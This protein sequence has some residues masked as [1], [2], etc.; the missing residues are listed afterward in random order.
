MAHPD[1]AYLDLLGQVLFEGVPSADRTGNGTIRLFGMSARFTPPKGRFPLL[2][3]KS[4]H[5]KSVA[6]EL[7]WFLSGSTNIKPLV[8]KGVRIWNKDAYRF[9]N[10]RVVPYLDDCT[11]P[12]N[13]DEFLDCVREGKR[14][15]VI[16]SSGAISKYRSGD[17]G[18]VYGKQ[19][20]SFGGGFDQLHRVVDEIRNNPTSRR[21]YVSAWNPEDMWSEDT[22]LPCCH[23]AFQFFVSGSRLSIKFDMRSN[24]LF[25]GLPFNIASYAL[26]QAMVCHL[27]GL[28]IG[29]IVYTCGDC[30]IYNGHVEAVTEQLTREPLELPRLVIRDRGQKL[31]TD[32]VIDDFI[33][34]DYKPHPAIKAEMYS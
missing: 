18:N 13:M 8:E 19:W 15:L 14:W 12:K 30:H 32:F 11:I 4:V 22:A 5:F 28:E 10:N 16:D 3:T 21:L 9:F 23:V 25:L 1:K 17:L 33:I 34:E 31:L 6:E 20:M 7:L 2:T 24:D 27:T 29:D 26:L